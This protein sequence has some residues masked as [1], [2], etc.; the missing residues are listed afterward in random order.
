MLVICR[1]HH[2]DF[3]KIS[4][5]MADFTGEMFQNGAYWPD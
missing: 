2:K 3:V 4:K 5:R 1:G